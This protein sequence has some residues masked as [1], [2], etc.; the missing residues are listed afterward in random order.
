MKNVLIPL[1]SVVRY[2]SNMLDVTSKTL[3]RRTKIRQRKKQVCVWGMVGMGVCVCGEWVWG[4]C[5]CVCV[6]VCVW[7]VGMEGSGGGWVLHS[8][9]VTVLCTEIQLSLIKGYGPQRFGWAT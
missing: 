7:G 1:Q 3:Y 2:L 8:I 6:C 5:V 9:S 4:M